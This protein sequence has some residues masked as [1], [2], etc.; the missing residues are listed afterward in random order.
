MKSD[1]QLSASYILAFTSFIC[2]SFILGAAYI[3]H[4]IDN[5]GNADIEMRIDIYTDSTG[6]KKYRCD[7]KEIKK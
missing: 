7:L 5:I 2:I 1:N 3:S 6:V 4:Q